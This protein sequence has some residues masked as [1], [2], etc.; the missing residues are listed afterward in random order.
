[1]FFFS[2]IKKLSSQLNNTKIG[3]PGLDLAQVT[4]W[5]FQAS[6]TFHQPKNFLINRKTQ[7]AIEM[8]KIQ[9]I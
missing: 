2:L 1:M 8:V 3:R 5:A 9:M 7:P 4:E 6:K